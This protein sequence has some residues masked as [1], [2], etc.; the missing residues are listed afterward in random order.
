MLKKIIYVE[1]DIILGSLITQALLAEGFEV[2]FLNALN[3]INAVI[4]AFQP[5]LLLLDLKVGSHS[6]LDELPFI[7]MQYPSIPVIFASSHTDDDEIARSYN[8]GV[9]QYIKK[10]YN[11]KELLI[12]INKLLPEVNTIPPCSIPLGKFRLNI[13][14]RELSYENKLIKALSLKEFK[15]LQILIENKGEVVLRSELLQKAW[16]NEEAS[17]SL[18]NCINA[19]RNLIKSHKQISIETAKGFGYCLKM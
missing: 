5:D 12:H 7:R 10:P 9:N 15:V 6:S 8:I 11:I 2:N 3:G 18:N 13:S 19:L 4:A 17:E 16:E 1:D 14:N